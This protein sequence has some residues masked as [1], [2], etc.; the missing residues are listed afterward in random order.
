MTADVPIRTERPLPPSGSVR[1]Y[2]LAEWRRDFGLVAGT[3]IGDDDTDFAL[4]GTHPIGQT[5]SAWR[6]LLQ[7]TGSFRSAVVSRQLHGAAIAT[8][9]RPV[10]DGV[11]IRDGFDGHVTS[12][13]G[14]LLAV[15]VAD[16]VPVF[17]TDTVTGGFGLVHAGWRGIAA[18]ILEAGVRA[19]TGGATVGSDVVMHCGI[20][21]CGA[22]YE[23]GPEVLSAVT[24][25][26][27]RTQGRLDLRSVLAARARAL[28]VGRITVS[29]FCTAH[30]SGFASFRA[31]GNRAGRMAA[32][33][34]RP[35]A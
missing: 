10:P 18:G 4:S 12:A 7:T 8:Y 30:D 15:T 13:R 23:V 35:P 27:A 21:I 1:C 34:G 5:L 32:F 26:A 19:V 6:H 24:G 9:G 20:A 29:P 25:R 16:C 22:C 11:L 3:A 17:L 33:L 31:Q 2:E 28:G 14:L